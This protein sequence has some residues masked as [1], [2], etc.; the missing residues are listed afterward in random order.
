MIIDFAY[1]SHLGTKASLKVGD[2]PYIAIPLCSKLK[3]IYKSGSS[4]RRYTVLRCTAFGIKYS[5][6]RLSGSC[7]VRTQIKGRWSP[8]EHFI[9][10][11][12]PTVSFSYF[13]FRPLHRGTELSHRGVWKATCTGWYG[14]GVPSSLLNNMGIS[15]QTHTPILVH[16]LYIYLIRLGFL[17]LKRHIQSIR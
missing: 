8:T 1:F 10:H 4:L 11:R 5:Q 17:Y 2:Q 12:G 9:T 16:C 3:E 13:A 15:S 6:L 14:L 7:A